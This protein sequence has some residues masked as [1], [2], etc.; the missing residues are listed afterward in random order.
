MWSSNIVCKAS[1]SPEF[2]RQH[3]GL[4][5]GPVS[6]IS[7][8]F[9][10][11]MPGILPDKEKSAPVCSRNFPE[12]PGRICVNPILLVYHPGESRHVADELTR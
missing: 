2:T 3:I 9:I 6:G 11:V 1:Q 8:I 4:K 7:L 10:S 5:S 12:I